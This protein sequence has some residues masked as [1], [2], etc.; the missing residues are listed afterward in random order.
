MKHREEIDQIVKQKAMAV[1]D[2]APVLGGHNGPYYDFELPIRN[3]SHWACIFSKYYEITGNV[4]Y[5]SAVEKL[6][7]EFIKT[8]NLID[9]QSCACRIK[10][11]KD[12]TNGVMGQ[13]WV[14]EGLL[15][16]AKTLN[17]DLF[18]NKAVTLFKVQRF[19]TKYGLWSVIE[20]DGR[21]F[22]FDITFNHQLWF[23]AAGSEIIAYKYDEEI[24]EQIKKFLECAKDFLYVHSNGLIFH[25]LKY[26]PKIRSW[27]WF[28]KTY[29]GAEQG[30]KNGKP[31]LVYKEEGYHLFSVYAFAILFETYG[32]ND[33]FQ[34]EKVK[35]AIKYAFDED[36]L[37]RLSNTDC[38][39][40]NTHICKTTD[41]MVN[42]YGYPYNSPAFE[43]PYISQVFGE[44]GNHDKLIDFLMDEQFRITYNESEGRF[45]KNTE[46]VETLNAR[47]YELVKA[48]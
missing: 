15:A 13:A 29:W 11:G 34:M 4:L 36:F 39:L 19:D 23:A 6:A 17:N 24:D 41:K 14:I 3:T 22:G 25:F 33:F 1:C 42:A 9:G 26:T 30:L 27:R 31:S 44:N 7:E 12:K 38:L 20:T 2:G 10:C 21:D 8:E 16:C 35:S 28:W 43:L 37:M 40:D 48:F 18:Y 46:D 5:H 32:E 47:L 45:S